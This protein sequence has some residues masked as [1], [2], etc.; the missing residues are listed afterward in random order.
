MITIDQEARQFKNLA[1]DID[2]MSD[3][4][5]TENGYFTFSSPTLWTIEKNLFYL[6][7]NSRRENFNQKYI[8]RPDYASFDEYGTVV[9][10]KLLMFVNSVVCVEN[11]NLDTIVYPSFSSIVDICQ[12]NFPQ[13]DPD[14]LIEVDW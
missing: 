10:D 9:L 11:F 1:I 14:D 7:R 3:R 8:M 6:L 4:Y 2:K 13:K 5:R 12:D